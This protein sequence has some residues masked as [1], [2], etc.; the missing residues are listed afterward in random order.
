LNK[1]ERLLMQTIKDKNKLYS[2]H[3]PHV[4]CIAKG[5]AH[6]KYEFGSKASV[7]ATNRECFVVGMMGLSGNPYDGLHTGWCVK[8]GGTINW[9]ENR[10][11][12][13]GSRL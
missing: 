3:E 10:T 9:T 7:T 8:T 13:C 2:L 5:K 11:G 4:V 6:K 1:A 12:V